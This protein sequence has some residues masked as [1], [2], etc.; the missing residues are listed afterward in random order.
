MEN[1]FR[2]MTL[3]DEIIYMKTQNQVKNKEISPKVQQTEE[4]KKEWRGTSWVQKEIEKK[5]LRQKR[6]N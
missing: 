6:N 4:G 2:W 3:N 1:E 5:E